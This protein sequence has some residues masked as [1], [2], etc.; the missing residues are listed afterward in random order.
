M[1]DNHFMHC[2]YFLG[3]P[4]IQQ[5]ISFDAGDNFVIE[6]NLTVYPLPFQFRFWTDNLLSAAFS[7]S[8]PNGL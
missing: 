4:Y 2:I 5:Y 3:C 6:T 1:D 8:A 7:F